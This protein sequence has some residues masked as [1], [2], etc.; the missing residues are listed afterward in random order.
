MMAQRLFLPAA[1]D[2]CSILYVGLELVV[3]L[4]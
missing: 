1:M 3:L 2:I 4:L